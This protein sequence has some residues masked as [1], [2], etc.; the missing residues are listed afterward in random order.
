MSRHHVPSSPVSADLVAQHLAA[1]VQC[2][3][4]APAP[5]TA[6]DPH[7]RAAFERQHELLREFYPHVFARAQADTLGTF[8]MLL[9]LPGRGADRPMVLM[10]HQDVVPASD[11][12]QAEGWQHAPFAGTIAAGRVWGRGTLDDKGSLVVLLEAVE[13]LLAEGWEPDQDLYL[14][15][16]ANEELLGTDAA[17]ATAMLAERGVQPY[18][19]LD[20]GGAVAGEAFA[21]VSRDVAVVGVSEKGVMSV[22][23]SV[24]HDGGHASTPP[25][26][27]A[28]GILARALVAVESHQMP[29]R[30]H[31]VTIEMFRKLGR[32]LPLPL[33]PVVA[34]AVR[35]GPALAAALVKAGPETAAIVRTTVAPTQLEGSA[36]ANVLATRASAVLNIRVAVGQTTQDVLTHLERVI[37]DDRVQFTVLESSEPSPVSPRDCRFDA[38]G[39]AVRASYPEAAVAPY[40]MMAASDARHL[41]RICPAVYRF[42]PLRMDKAQRGSIHGIEENVAVES[43]GRGVVFYRSL[44]TGPLMGPGSAAGSASTHTAQA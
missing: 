30:V 21:G 23:L 24:V 3:T 44:L 9:R 26:P 5:G 42:S 15:L 38:I 19:V 41:A 43:L 35:L 29:A 1:L 10:A 27:S 28:P 13:S 32:Q 11:D 2:A 36:G 20:E 6:P 34:G 7:T 22:R 4:V 37:A 12:W 39:A 40:I 18:V 8:G 25:V 31:P 33:R 16:G 14:L 17:D